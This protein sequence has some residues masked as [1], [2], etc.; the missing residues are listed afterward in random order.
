[1]MHEADVE[2]ILQYPDTMIGSDGI[3][4][5][6]KPHPRQWGTFPRVLGHYCRTRKLFSL[7]TAVYKMSGLVA[8]EFG[9]KDRGT[10]EVD[11]VADVTIFDAETVI[12]RATFD[13]PTE[14]A[15]GIEW[16]VVNG[17][18]AWRDGKTVAHAGQLLTRGG[19]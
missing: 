7:E 3:P 8:R 2:R 5:Q 11:K 17:K 15:V 10:L 4:M 9:L 19:A 18:V 16:V 12:D 1:M 13:A 6:E 14:A